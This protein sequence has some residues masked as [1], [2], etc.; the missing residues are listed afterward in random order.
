MK[1]EGT[2]VTLS[3]TKKHLK[4]PDAG[5]GR[6]GC[7]SRDFGGSVARGHL[8]FRFLRSGKVRKWILTV[9]SH[10]VIICCRRSRN[11]MG[12]RKKTGKNCQILESSKIVDTLIY[13]MRESQW[14][15]C[16]FLAQTIH[17][18]GKILPWDVIYCVLKKVREYKRNSEV[19]PSPCCIEGPLQ[20]RPSIF[21][22]KSFLQERK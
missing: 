5:S 10:Q 17:E 16:F 21:T 9:W 14:S 20:D 2:G 4:P 11:L 8:D 22:G 3:Q 15:P 7:F 13:Q 18:S 12:G 1:T 19:I 6:E